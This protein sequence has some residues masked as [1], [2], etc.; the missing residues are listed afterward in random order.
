MSPLDLIPGPWKLAAYAG[1]AFIV[2]GSIGAVGVIIEKRGYD[3]AVSL[4]QPK[5]DQANQAIGV[6]TTANAADQATI[7]RMQADQQANEAL[8]SSY[9]DRVTALNQQADDTASAIR[10]LQNDDQSV[11]VYLRTAVPAALRSVLDGS[12]A[13]PVNPAGADNHSLPAAAR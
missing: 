6:L 9:A 7:Q 4:L 5:L 13:G 2:L 11:D 3:K 8:L 12:K 10:K 1:A